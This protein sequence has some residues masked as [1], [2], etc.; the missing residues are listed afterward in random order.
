MAQTGKFTVLKKSGIKLRRIGTLVTRCDNEET[1][2]KVSIMANRNDVT[3]IVIC[4]GESNTKRNKSQKDNK[5]VECEKD[6]QFS[7]TNAEGFLLKI[8][9]Y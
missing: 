4:G 8:K 1:N 5:S 6:D 3:P 2:L 7:R 9:R